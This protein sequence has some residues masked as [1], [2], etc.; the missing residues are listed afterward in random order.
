MPPT[1][2]RVDRWLREAEADAL[3]QQRPLKRPTTVE[4][5][6]DGWDDSYLPRE[7]TPD[8]RRENPLRKAKLER[9]F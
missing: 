7:K 3:R 2:D 5:D 6:D 4:Y 9:A 1:D 8:Y